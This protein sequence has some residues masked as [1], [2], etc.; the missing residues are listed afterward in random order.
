VQ[1]QYRDTDSVLSQ[2]LPRGEW[3]V[4]ECLWYLHQVNGIA[5]R[6]WPFLDS[7]TIA[8]LLHHRS[9]RLLRESQHTVTVAP[10]TPPICSFAL[11]PFPTFHRRRN[12][13]VRSLARTSQYLNHAEPERNCSL[14]VGAH[15]RFG[16]HNMYYEVSWAQPWLFRLI[17]VCNLPNSHFSRL[18]RA[19]S[20]DLAHCRD[21]ED[22]GHLLPIH[23]AAFWS[24]TLSS[25]S[26]IMLPSKQ[27]LCRVQFLESGSPSGLW[28]TDC[29]Q[30]LRVTNALFD[31]RTNKGMKNIKAS[32][33]SDSTIILK[34]NGQHVD[35]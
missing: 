31:V 4:L 2:S 32:C 10:L 7:A 18:I 13:P 24:P 8:T 33:G 34:V 5:N 29:L 19:L 1:R 6:E 23:Q 3:E 16:A 11:L 27:Q 14:G 21:W 28:E 9:L 22:W 15:L 25:S 26:P 17:H 20:T 35:Y 30:G 12:T